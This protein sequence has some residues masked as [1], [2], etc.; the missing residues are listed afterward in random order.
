MKII[1]NET[2]NKNLNVELRSIKKFA[3]TFQKNNIVQRQLNYRGIILYNQLP[4][5][6][7]NINPLT[8]KIKFR[9]LL[10]DY[11]LTKPP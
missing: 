5:D 8:D 9:N 1:A 2:I 3:I 10:K 11:S 7:S 6:I 4:Q